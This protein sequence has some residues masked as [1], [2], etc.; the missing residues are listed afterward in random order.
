MGAAAA[1]VQLLPAVDYVLESS[2]RVQTTREDAGEVDELSIHVIPVLI[3]K[4]IPLIAPRH[5]TVPLKL[6]G[7]RKYSDGVIRLHYAVPRQK[8]RKPRKRR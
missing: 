7:S 2:R 6:I 8:A 3:G 4:G 1:G 5:R